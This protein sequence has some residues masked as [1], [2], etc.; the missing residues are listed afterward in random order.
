MHNQI[1]VTQQ[2][3]IEEKSMKNIIVLTQLIA[4]ISLKKRVFN[5]RFLLTSLLFIS[6]SAISATTLAKAQS[7]NEQQSLKVVLAP[8]DP[9][10]NLAL[11]NKVLSPLDVQI[12]PHEQGF[13]REIKPFMADN[14]YQAVADLFKKRDL[15][16][17]G[18]ALQL[19][20]GQILLMLKDF[21]N[22]ELA[23]KA[24]LTTMPDLAKAHQGLSL[25]YMQQQQYKKAQQ[26]L[27][28]SVELGRADAQVYAQ[29]GFIHV[30]NDQ[31][32]S[33][34]AAYRQALMLQPEQVQ[35]Q[36]GLLFALIE[37]GDFTQARVLL[38][39]L[40]NKTPNDEQ[41]WLQRGQ[42]AL[43]Q[44]DQQ[45]ALTNIEIALK[46]KPT[47][48]SNQLLAAQLHLNQGSSDRAVEL[49]NS[50]LAYLSDKQ[51]KA[52]LAVTLQTLNWLVVQQQWPLTQQLITQA[53]KVES[54]FNQQQKAQFSVYSAQLAIE[55][56]QLNTALKRLNKAIS[57]D[58]NLGDALLS[59]ANIYHQ[60][61]QLTQAKLMYVRAQSLP[62]FQLSAWL[63]LAQIEID[64]QQYKAALD[65]L[66]KA[67]KAHPERQDLMTNIRALDKLVRHES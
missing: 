46:L 36:K 31:P 29:L 25:L 13:A 5:V 33:A 14:Q 4:M 28:R 7:L 40:I 21:P 22:A 54:K 32:W 67:F 11:D 37:S 51:E 44:G 63:G 34:I 17:D 62:E 65:Y 56:G 1:N 66:K 61:N 64:S 9:Q 47:D 16:N 57:I 12:S 3:C 10:W 30:Q 49:L 27:I 35:Y 6:V 48:Q 53:E 23:F 52:A 45:Q 60:K 19:L 38:K 59:L 55:K 58:P 42:I 39:E 2:R 18:T 50:V 24:C 41:L 15:A 26:H 20:R 8:S 43:Q